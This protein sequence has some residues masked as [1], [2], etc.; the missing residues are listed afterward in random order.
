MVIKCSIHADSV[1]LL[2]LEGTTGFVNVAEDVQSTIGQCGA[3]HARSELTTTRMLTLLCLITDAIRRTVGQKDL[4]SG[5]D[6]FVDSLALLS[7][8]FILECT[9][10]VPRDSLRQVE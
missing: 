4:R 8:T 5:R 6:L 3:R 7:V 10:R 1:G 2:V 9:I